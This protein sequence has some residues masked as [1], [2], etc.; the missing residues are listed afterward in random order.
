M[1][2]SLWLLQNIIMILLWLINWHGDKQF[3]WMRLLLSYFLI[4]KRISKKILSA[5]GLDDWNKSRTI[6]N[7]K[8][9]LNP[10]FSKGYS[11][12]IERL[13]EGQRR[14]MLNPAENLLLGRKEALFSPLAWA[15]FRKFCSFGDSFRGS[16]SLFSAPTSGLVR[17]EVRGN[18][19]E[20]PNCEFRATFLPENL[21]T[22]TWKKGLTEPNCSRADWTWKLFHEGRKR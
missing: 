3:F 14:E 16:F 8:V 12:E 9:C 15:G 22:R 19:W 6:R 21:G 2:G 4:T 11:C 20:R 1:D 5:L 13:H 10:C 7:A 17:L 18:S